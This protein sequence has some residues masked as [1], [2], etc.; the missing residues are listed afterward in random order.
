MGRGFDSRHLHHFRLV[1]MRVW[2]KF[3]ELNLQIS[4]VMSKHRFK[5]SPF[6]NPSGGKAYRVSGTLDGKSIRKNFKTRSDAVA[7]RQELE[8]QFLQGESEGQTVWTTLTHDQNRDAIAA[9]NL[10]K[11]SN[12]TKSLTFAV[13]YFLDHYKEAAETMAVEAAVEEYTD[14]R[15]REFERGIISRRQERAISIEMDNLK[16]YFAGRIVGEIRGDELREYL[17]KT[18]GRSKAV[19]SLK[20]WNNRQR[21]YTRPVRDDLIQKIERHRPRTTD[22]LNR[23]WYGYHN[24]RPQ[25]YDGTRYHGVNL[26][27]VWYRGTV[28]FRWFE[29]TL[30]AGK[31]KSYIQLVLAVATKAL[32]GRAAS[33]RKRRFDP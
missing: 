11:E 1:F 32:N 19:P 27:N 10:L 25:H 8:I 18:R 33:S 7:Y 23:I 12:S 2:L 17:D 15:S 26:H 29:A 6:T 14:E 9:V 30:H 28:E 22:Q 16:D 21:P 20:T 31:V 4:K 5:I 24:S 3:A 13:K